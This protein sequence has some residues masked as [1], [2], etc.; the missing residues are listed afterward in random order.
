MKATTP[1]QFNVGSTQALKA[2]IAEMVADFTRPAAVKNAPDVKATEKEMLEILVTVATDRRFKT[3]DKVDENGNPVF[4]S[5]GVQEFKTVDLFEVEWKKILA[6]D[7]AETAPVSELEKRL[8][9]ARKFS[10]ILG[11]SAEQIETL[12][13]QV[14]AQYEKEQAEAAAAIAAMTPAPAEA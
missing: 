2:Q 13:E 14:K 9:T 8:A 6:R 10:K 5:D 12:L 1:K 11:S 3:V 4:D 7:Y